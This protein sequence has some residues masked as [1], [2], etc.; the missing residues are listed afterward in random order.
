[1]NKNINNKIIVTEKYLY[2]YFGRY[3]R[4]L[5]ISSYLYI[6]TNANYI[7]IAW[8]NNIFVIFYLLYNSDFNEF[9]IF[10]LKKSLNYFAL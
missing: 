8:R 10:I 1:M 9:W 7:D 4:K 6:L 5:L 2:L 3:I